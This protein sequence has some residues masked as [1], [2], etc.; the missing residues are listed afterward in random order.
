MVCPN[1]EPLNGFN[2]LNIAHETTKFK[3]LAQFYK[4]DPSSLM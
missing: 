3:A 1:H 4:F 2:V